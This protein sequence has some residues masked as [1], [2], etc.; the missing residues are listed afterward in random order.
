VAERQHRA[1]RSFRRSGSATDNT[2]T[3]NWHNSLRTGGRWL[4]E[5]GNVEKDNILVPT[6]DWPDEAQAVIDKAGPR[7]EAGK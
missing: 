4:A 6:R 3:G 2:A 1:A 5:I 7:P